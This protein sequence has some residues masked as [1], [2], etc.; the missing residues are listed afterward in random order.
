M[1]G[2]LPNGVGGSSQEYIKHRW[3]PWC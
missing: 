3:R 2:N 1:F